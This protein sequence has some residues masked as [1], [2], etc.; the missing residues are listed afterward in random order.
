[1][2]LSG[3]T[4]MYYRNIQYLL[5][6]P[7][8]SFPSGIS[9][10]EVD[11][12]EHV[13]QYEDVDALSVFHYREP[14]RGQP[15]AFL[16]CGGFVYPLLR[17]SSPVLKAGERTYMFPELRKEGVCVGWGGWGCVC[18]QCVCHCVCM[19]VWGRVC[20]YNF[21]LAYQCL[22]FREFSLAQTHSASSS[23]T[24]T[25]P[26]PPPPDGSVV[27]V[28]LGGASQEQLQQLDQLLAELGSLHTSTHMYTETGL[29]P[30]MLYTWVIVH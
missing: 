24:V 22:H 20:V 6:H 18:V 9:L 5:E 30:P 28:V 25:V 27:G 2:Y 29:P 8:S 10:F 26:P 3:C 7:P 11:S 23:L 13:R 21:I 17:G 12:T 19:H 16:Q 4:Y 15:P 1:M 14:I